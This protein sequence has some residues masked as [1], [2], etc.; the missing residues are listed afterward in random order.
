MANTT[1]FTL[2]FVQTENG[3]VARFRKMVADYRL[4][5]QTLEELQSLSSREL[6]DLGLSRAS[7][8]QIAREAVYGA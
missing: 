3:L 8:R 1:T 6:A 4:Y 7:V 5:R 2:D